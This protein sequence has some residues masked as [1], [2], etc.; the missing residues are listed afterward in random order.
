[1]KFNNF[2]HNGHYCSGTADIPALSPTYW[3][4]R[5]RHRSIYLFWSDLLS[6]WSGR[7]LYILMSTSNKVS[8]FL[9]LNQSTSIQ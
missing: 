4:H 7:S 2:W 5:H 1:M 6:P 3:R 9:A 8:L